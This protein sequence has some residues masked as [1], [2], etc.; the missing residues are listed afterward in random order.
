MAKFEE[1]I[2]DWMPLRL[3]I[4]RKGTAFFSPA[5]RG[6]YMDLILAYWELGP[7]PNDDAILQQLARV[8]DSKTWKQVRGKVLGKFN[9]VDGMLTHA[10]VDEERTVALQK[11]QRKSDAGRVAGQASAQARAKQP[12]TTGSTNRSTV[13]STT[14]QPDVNTTYQGHTPNGVTEAKASGERKRSAPKV[15]TRISPDWKPN[16]RNLEDAKARGYH[17]ADIE[18]LAQHFRDYHLAKGTVSKDWDASWRTWLAN[19]AK[20]SAQR[21]NGVNGQQSRHNRPEPGSIVELATRLKARAALGGQNH[22][23]GGMGRGGEWV[24]TSGDER[25]EMGVGFGAGGIVI[26]ADEC[27]GNYRPVDRTETP[28]EGQGGTGE[29]PGG[30]ASFVR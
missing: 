5:E 6:A 16:E 23:D 1:K 24:Q 3:V 20:F 7:L 14:G 12:S 8:T 9:E 22:R 29:G 28:N 2:A 4:W 27:G 19:D 30:A 26:E 13:G 15:G 21:G 10:R 25:D 18:R 11:F 17:A